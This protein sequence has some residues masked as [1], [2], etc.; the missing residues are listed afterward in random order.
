MV[1]LTMYSLTQELYKKGNAIIASSNIKHVIA[2]T[3]HK[4]FQTVENE[5]CTFTRNRYFYMMEV[6]LSIA[7]AFYLTIGV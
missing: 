1:Q 6:Y 5:Y 4:Q 3:Y 2:N 7:T